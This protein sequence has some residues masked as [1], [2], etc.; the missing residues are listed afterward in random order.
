[1]H[2]FA[3][4]ASNSFSGA[5][6]VDFLLENPAHEVIGITRSEK[7]SIFLPYKKR[8]NP[9]FKNYIL[10]VNTEFQ[11]IADVLDDLK[12]DYVINFAAQGEVGSSWK[13]PEN[14]FETN[15]VAVARLANFL[16]GKKYLKR[17]VHISTPEVYGTC[18]G[19]V[20]ES[21]PLNPST[22]Y[23][24]SKAAGDLSLFTFVKNFNF[25]LVIVRS[26]NVYGAHQQL[27]RIIPKTC[28][29][30]KMG[31]KIGLQGAGEAVKSYIHVR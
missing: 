13:Y 17:Y 9:S 19:N 10:N 27:Y 18:E 5:H 15:A 31:R 24:A 16:Q 6:L 21:A 7:G 1:M 29:F 23:A 22:P 25:P 28:K 30:I 26:T 2:R 12:P 4:I 11:K 14:W 3:V 8:E 20:L